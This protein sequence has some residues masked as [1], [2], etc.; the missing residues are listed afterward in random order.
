LSA[1]AIREEREIWSK[2]RREIFHFRVTMRLAAAWYRLIKK[3][4]LMSFIDSK[5][6]T[7]RLDITNKYLTTIG[8]N[9]EI[10]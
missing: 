3:K 7:W 10:W 1:K 5:K 2:E 8:N 9:F 4:I 6:I